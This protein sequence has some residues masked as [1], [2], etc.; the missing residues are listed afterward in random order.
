MIVSYVD[1]SYPG[2][3]RPVDA[4]ILMP[5]NRIVIRFKNQPHPAMQAHGKLTQ[6]IPRQRMG[7]PCNQ[8]PNM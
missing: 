7:M 1:N 6:T 5:G 3:L 8:V 2:N 4:A